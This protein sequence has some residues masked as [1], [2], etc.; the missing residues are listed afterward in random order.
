MHVVI[1]GASRGIGL[2]FVRQYLAR[3]D[4]VVAACREP[5]RADALAAAAA[6]AGDRARVAAC[7]V[8]SDAS[9]AAFAASLGDAT[10]D[11]LVNNAGVGGG[12]ESL[13]GVATEVALETYNV[14][15]LGPVRVTRALLPHLARSAAPR[16]AHVSSG[17]GSIGDNG[18]GGAYAYRMSK[19]ALN[20]AS[21]NLAVDLRPRG[22]VSV[23][24]NPGWV[25]TDMGGADAPTGARESVAAMIARFDALTLADSGRFLDWKRPEGFPW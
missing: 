21:R 23:V 14:N 16:V 10:V 1:T 22:V 5:A 3:G 13:D 12:W 18:S 2:E 4:R 20:M 11:L 7:D 9:V 8:A 24:I 6:P 17:M 25:Q 19:A 15:A